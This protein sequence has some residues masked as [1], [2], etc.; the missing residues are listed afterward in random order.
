MRDENFQDNNLLNNFLVR[1]K[2]QSVDK[3][4]KADITS[5]RLLIHNRKLEQ[6]VDEFQK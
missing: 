4:K 5:A 1:T 2:Q 6:A 3:K